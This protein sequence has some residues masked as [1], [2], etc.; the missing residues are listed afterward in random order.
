VLW[1]ALQCWIADWISRKSHRAL[2]E[3]DGP[4]S[5]LAR[6]DRPSRQAVEYVVHPDG[7]E[8][9]T[10]YRR[11]EGVYEYALEGFFVTDIPEYEVHREYWAPIGHD[12][13]LFDSIGTAK[14]D[15][16]VLYPWVNETQ[17]PERD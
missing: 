17:T 5:E 16:A 3:D 7:T 15:A 10:I 9:L 8:R 1:Q 2:Y 4:K 12:S 6:N 11:P 14:R 13:G